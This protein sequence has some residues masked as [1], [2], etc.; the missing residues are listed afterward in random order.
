MRSII[1]LMQIINMSFHDAN[2]LLWMGQYLILHNN[3]QCLYNAIPVVLSIESYCGI[4]GVQ[5]FQ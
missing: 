4:S 5:A 1:K 2:L 3:A